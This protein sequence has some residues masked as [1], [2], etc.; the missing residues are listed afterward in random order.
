MKKKKN[1]GNER[2]VHAW[3]TGIKY[4]V[5]IGWLAELAGIVCR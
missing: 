1:Y 2:R 4:G 3:V 5:L